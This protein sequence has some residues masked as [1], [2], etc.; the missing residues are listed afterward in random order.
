MYTQLD[1]LL[2]H[3]QHACA[4]RKRKRTVTEAE[5]SRNY[6][7]KN[8][9]KQNLRDLNP[10]N[11]HMK[12]EHPGYSKDTN[13]DLL[14]T[15]RQHLQH[16]SRP[17]RLAPRLTTTLHEPSALPQANPPHLPC[18]F[19]YLRDP[20]NGG[21]GVAF[22][23]CMWVDR[24]TLGSLQHLGGVRNLTESGG[25]GRPPTISSRRAHS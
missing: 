4:L 19:K 7:Y 18:P 13:L 24:T 25:R 6:V 22:E 11:N 15:Q 20:Q 23:P 8:Q 17:H 3:A 2:S 12:K 21:H 10:H 16:R 5:H 1:V 9:V 14:Q